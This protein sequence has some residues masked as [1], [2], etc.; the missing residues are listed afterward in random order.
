MLSALAVPSV[1][2][3]LSL[4]WAVAAAPR[5][6]G[7]TLLQAEEGK[8]ECRRMLFSPK[9][10]PEL[11]GRISFR[12]VGTSCRGNHSRRKGW[13]TLRFLLGLGSSGQKVCNNCTL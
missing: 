3:V 8:Q 11:A 13:L 6:V 2:D 12:N 9:L 5:G 1:P 4:L 7:G 10:A